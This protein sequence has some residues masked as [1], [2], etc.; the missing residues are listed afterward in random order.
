MVV[1]RVSIDNKVELTLHQREMGVPSFINQNF[2]SSFRLLGMYKECLT[3]DNNIVKKKKD[4]HDVICTFYKIIFLCFLRFTSSLDLF[5][6]RSLCSAG[7]LH[8]YEV[9]L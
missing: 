5:T 4:L 7:G 2:F 6:S 8:L 9:Q 3:L 1:E